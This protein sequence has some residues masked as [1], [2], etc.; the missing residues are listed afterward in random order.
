MTDEI[1]VVDHVEGITVRVQGKRA[2]AELTQLTSSPLTGQDAH[3]PEGHWLWF[4]RLINQSGEPGLGG[5]LLDRLLEYCQ[6]AGYSIFNTVNAYDHTK[7][8]SLERWY[9]KKG[10]KPLN[11]EVFG[12][13]VLIWQPASTLVE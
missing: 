4:N 12:N 8:H 3:L 1:I 13:G 7:Q 9:M 5:R 10:F 6:E 2:V 11:P